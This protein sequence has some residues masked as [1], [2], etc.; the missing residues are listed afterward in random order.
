MIS[1]KWLEVPGAEN[2]EAMMTSNLHG[3]N[4]RFGHLI[5]FVRLTTP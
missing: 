4:G 5:I 2:A 3:K 1:L